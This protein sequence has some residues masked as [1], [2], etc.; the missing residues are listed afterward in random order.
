MSEKTDKDLLLPSRAPSLEEPPARPTVFR[1]TAIAF[2][3]L[4]GVAQLIFWRATSDS[5][6]HIST[7]DKSSDDFCPQVSELLP[8]KNGKVWQQLSETFSSEGFKARAINWIG[9]AVRVP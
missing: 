3:I 7:Y 4:L 5:F 1:K 9:D 2:W 6:D 8:N